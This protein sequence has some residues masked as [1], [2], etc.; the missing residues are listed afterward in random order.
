[1]KEKRGIR[2]RGQKEEGRQKIRQVVD[3]DRGR[4]K[5]S[6]SGRGKKKTRKTRIF[7]DRL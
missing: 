7:H 6:E 5:R 3:T 4:G 2:G 1:M